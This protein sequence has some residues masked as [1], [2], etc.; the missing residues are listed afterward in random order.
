MPAGITCSSL[1]FGPS[2][3]TT[4][5]STEYFTPC[6][7]AI[8]FFPIRDISNP[9]WL[10]SPGVASLHRSTAASGRFFSTRP[11]LNPGPSARPLLFASARTARAACARP[12]RPASP[13]FAQHFATHAFAPGLATG[14]DALRGRHDADAQPALHALNLA[15]TA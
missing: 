11:A 15:A 2:T 8:G 10:A 5:P 14:H 7:N 6:G 3:T 13:D 4:V 1:P 9:L 12:T